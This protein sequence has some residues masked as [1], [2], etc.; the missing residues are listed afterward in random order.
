MNLAVS[1][2]LNIG[3]ILGRLNLFLHEVT[4]RPRME[5]FIWRVRDHIVLRPLIL[6]LAAVVIGIV[7]GLGAVAFRA[8]IALF[9]NLLFLRRL[10]FSYDAT[11][12]TPPS[13][14]GV[15]IILVPVVG[16]VCVAFLVKNFAPEAKGHGVPEVM[17]AIYY[18]KGVIRPVVALVKSLASAISIGSGGSIGREGPIIQ[19]GAAFGSTLGQVLR[20]SLWQRITL[21]AAGTGGAIAATFNTPVGGVLFAMEITMHEVSA[22]TL[23]PVAIATATATYIGRLFFGPHPSFLIPAFQTP[24]F[25]LAKPWVLICYVGLGLLMGLV[26]A[27]F[28]HSLYAF[29]TFFETRIKG[30]YYVQ[31]CLGMLG[32]GVMM[33]LMLARF[34]HYYIEGVG[35]STIQDVLSGGRVSIHLLL[36]LCA[37]KLVATSLTLGSGASGGV[38]SPALFLG[39]T[40]GAAYGVMLNHIYPALDISAPG[41]AVAAMGGVVGGTTGAAMAAIVM[42]FEMTMDYRVII[43][44]TITVAL[45]YAVRRM[46][47]RDSIYTRKLALRGHT[48]PEALQTNLHFVRRASGIMDKD[49]AMA[50]GSQTIAEVG[51]ASTGELPRALVVTSREENII[52]VITRDQCFPNGHVVSSDKLECIARK[53]YVMVSSEAPFT[54][55]LALMRLQHASVALVAAPKSSNDGSRHTA[56]VEGVITEHRLVESLEAGLDLFG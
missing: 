19:I 31:H 11:A 42:I 14:F 30:G 37:L 8:L 18:N 38:F 55:I 50:N 17:D 5:W 4:F 26:S 1:Q 40:L 32:V 15:F 2:R 6:W 34:G 28:I 27:L 44:L 33:Y 49:F 46:L 53:D 48:M 13:P 10:S 21:I 47:V 22:R 7:A 20:L 54:E 35:Y 29:E 51:N 9:H 41:F 25:H 16:A 3:I 24:Y 23:V 45:S 52:G 36:L 56:K 43:P 39:A 12:H